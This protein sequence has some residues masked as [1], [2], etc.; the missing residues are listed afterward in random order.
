MQDLMNERGFDLLI[1]DKAPD[2]RF[3]TGCQDA[4]G[5][6]LLT[7]SG[8]AVLVTNAHDASQA[9]GEAVDTTVLVW[10]PGEDPLALLR[11]A[12][13]PTATTGISMTSSASLAEAFRD[14]GIELEFA[15]GLTSDLR[16]VKE[17]PELEIIRRAARIVEAGMVA[18][19]TALKPGVRE[20]EVAAAAEQAMRKLGMDGRVFETK[21]ESGPRSAWPSTYAG[22]RELETGD[23]VLIDIGPT[24]HGYFG[25]LTRT[26]SVGS[27]S[28][29][30]R[31]ILELVL[32]LQTEALSVVRAGISGH[33]ADE[34]AR[35][36]VRAAGLE[37]GFLH[38]TGHSLGLAGDALPL[39]RPGSEDV[40]RAGECVTVEPGVYREG[41]GG[42]RIEDEVL[43]TA[44]G[45]ELLTSF[46][47]TIESLIVTV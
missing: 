9:R 44:S 15:A 41:I 47:K 42:A 6:M 7:V 3:F 39:L 22:E 10:R 29:E 43:V 23:L 31:A 16:R 35:R 33:D 11:T 28:P 14:A 27:P 20:I 26:F 13:P 2:I 17:P 12:I 4:G 18:A 25:D 38:N 1:S 5:I 37:D 8:D 40:L 30:T 24:F 21:V 19:R 36:V 34:A 32:A 45:H 46:P